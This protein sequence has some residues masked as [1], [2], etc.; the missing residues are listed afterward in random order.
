MDSSHIFFSLWLIQTCVHRIIMYLWRNIKTT[1]KESSAPKIKL[2]ETHGR[3]F[4]S[5]RTDGRHFSLLKRPTVLCTCTCIQ[6]NWNACTCI[7]I[8]NWKCIKWDNISDIKIEKKAWHSVKKCTCIQIVW[9]SG[10]QWRRKRGTYL[11][12]FWLE[13]PTD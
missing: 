1:V 11:S 7:Q 8:H 4:N 10:T 9:H 5:M 2:E 12:V 13:D 6:I 3:H